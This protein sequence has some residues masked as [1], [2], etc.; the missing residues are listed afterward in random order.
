MGSIGHA[1]QCS[2]VPKQNC[3][4]WR[5]L[6]IFEPGSESAW[7]A[8]QTLFDIQSQAVN[9]IAEANAGQVVGNGAQAISAAQFVIDAMI[10]GAL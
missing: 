9:V 2:P 8:A 6:F 10:R 4:R 5:N 7:C 3:S 1:F